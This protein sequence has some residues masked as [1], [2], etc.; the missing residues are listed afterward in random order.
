RC[1]GARGG[2]LAT[3]N[4]A[5]STST[6]R[7]DANPPGWVTVSPEPSS[8]AQ[9]ASAAVI[10]GASTREA[11]SGPTASHA[12]GM[13]SRPVL[14]WATATAVMASESTSGTSRSAGTPD[15]G[16]GPGTPSATPLP[17]RTTDRQACRP[18]PPGRR[19]GDTTPRPP[20]PRHHRPGPGQRCR[21]TT[22]AG[23]GNPE[24]GGRP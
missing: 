8:S 13:S 18:P 4:T 17:E 22:P 10:P 14:Y 16:A 11:S 9:P 3:A 19:G 15:G 6:L 12:T 24:T 2:E 21:R 7:C 23:R 5:S 1:G 20:P